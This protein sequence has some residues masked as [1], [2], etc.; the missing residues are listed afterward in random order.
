MITQ[1]EVA[2]EKNTKLEAYV[3]TY[4]HPLPRRCADSSTLTLSALANTRNLRLTVNLSRVLN[5][6]HLIP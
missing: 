1:Y 6:D 5:F 3:H 4:L 2:V